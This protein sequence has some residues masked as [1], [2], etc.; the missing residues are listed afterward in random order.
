MKATKVQKIVLSLIVMVGLSGCAMFNKATVTHTRTTTIGK[1]LIDLQDAK[2]K[3]IDSD[4]EF[5]K[6]KK[7]IMKGGPSIDAISTKKCG[8]N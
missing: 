8:C 4:E 2:E 7:E 1:E 6:L 5:G 3:G